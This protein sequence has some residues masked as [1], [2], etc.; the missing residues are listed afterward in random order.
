MRKNFSTI[1]AAISLQALLAMGATAETIK[2]RE[3]VYSYDEEVRGLEE[4]VFLLCTDCPDSQL[5]QIYSIAVRYSRS[6]EGGQNSRP[7]TESVE[8]AVSA[9]LPE[10]SPPE[11]KILGIIR[12]PFDSYVL[13]TATKRQL[14]GLDLSN[15]LVRL[16]GYTCSIGPENYN[17]KL[18]QRRARS[19]SKY[20]KSK[21]VSILEAI[22]IGESQKFKNKSANRRVEII[23]DTKE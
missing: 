13:S 8:K 4:D 14:D 22:G 5:T 18:S 20:L 19:V 6:S 23:D 7:A 21:G 9:P 1:V 3:Y 16:E 11:R 2:Q 17:L 12:F 15:K 10:V